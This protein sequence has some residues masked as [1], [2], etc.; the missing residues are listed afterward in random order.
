MNTQAAHGKRT[1]LFAVLRRISG[2]NDRT[3]RGS[4]A[5]DHFDGVPR[6]L[7]DELPI[8]EDVVEK[9]EFTGTTRALSATIA[10]ASSRRASRW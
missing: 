2:R 3:T 5:F 1:E 9:V 7:G 8:E 10:S 6:L 4:R